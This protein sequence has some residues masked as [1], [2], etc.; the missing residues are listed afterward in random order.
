MVYKYTVLDSKTFELNIATAT[1]CDAIGRFEFCSR[2]LHALSPDE[3]GIWGPC[4]DPRV[5]AYIRG[6][7]PEVSWQRQGKTFIG[8]STEDLT[9]AYSKELMEA[10]QGIHGYRPDEF[11]KTLY[12]FSIV[13]S[14]T[15]RVYSYTFQN[16][17][18]PVVSFC[19]LWDQE[20][21]PRD[22]LEV[23][24]K[25]SVLYMAS[26]TTG[27]PSGPPVK[28]Y[29]D[30]S[31]TVDE[32]RNEGFPRETDQS[33]RGVYIEV[34]RVSQYET[35]QE[36]YKLLNRVQSPADQ[37]GRSQIPPKYK[38]ELYQRSGFACSNCG[39]V[40][41]ERYLAPD[42]RVPSIVEADDLSEANYL[43][44]LQTLCVRCNQVKR[45]ACKK[46]PYEHD[47]KKCHWAYPEKFGVSVANMNKLRELAA[48]EGTTI[49]NYLND[50]LD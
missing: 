38:R 17:S 26:S 20:N 2:L 50:L 6:F 23:T 10:I 33:P 22:H 46:C 24:R 48:A 42:H 1:L 5:D 4:T 15:N 9:E 14:S 41:E 13:D 25:A 45:E 12:E 21:H 39:G 35:L 49:N 16:R 30:P 44:V 19:V 40:F 43:E 31:K 28:T 36:H 27:V 47:C 37:V 11:S 18:R 8:I 32:L 29:G 7:P 34:T 3:L